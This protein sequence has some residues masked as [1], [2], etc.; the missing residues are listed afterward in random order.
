MKLLES[1][2]DN[3]HAHDKLATWCNTG[4]IS[5][6]CGNFLI[7]TG[8]FP[9]IAKQLYDEIKTIKSGKFEGT[10]TTHYHLDHT[11]GNQI[12]TSKPIYAHRYCSVNFGNYDEKELVE[13]FA[14]RENKELFEG[15]KLSQA[16]NIYDT[17]A[18]SPPENSDITCYLTGGHTSG[19]V[20]VHYKPDD[21]V[22]AGDNLFAMTF[23]WGGDPT[24]DPYKMVTAVDKILSFNPQIVVPGHGPIQHNVDDL[25]FFKNYMEKVLKTGER[26]LK[27]NKD[28]DTIFTELM[29]IPSHEPRSE[30]MKTNSIKHWITVMKNH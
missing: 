8:M 11:G 7:D 30:H 14:K 21:I 29:K 28:D 1:I 20:I 6:D 15:F 26:M 22:F 18:F 5:S 27:E 24:A 13:D 3:I 9:V 10:F 4:V 12:F 2:S 23:P 19:S 17:D 25:H 16:S